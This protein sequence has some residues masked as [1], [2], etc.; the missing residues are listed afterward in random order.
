MRLKNA[1]S[2]AQGTSE[3]LPTFLVQV[4][5]KPTPGFFRY[6]LD[7]KPCNPY[8]KVSPHFSDPFDA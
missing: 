1:S 6:R 8:T 7:L 2:W 3:A 4:H 5:T